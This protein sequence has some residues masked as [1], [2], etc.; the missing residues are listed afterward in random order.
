MASLR[1]QLRILPTRR[2]RGYAAE[3]RMG[4]QFKYS[5]S[6]VGFSPGIEVALE[7]IEA[8]R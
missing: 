2:H 7:S 5:A 3:E 6:S 8:S 1:I 4:R